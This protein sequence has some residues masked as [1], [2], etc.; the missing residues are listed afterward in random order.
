MVAYLRTQNDLID[1]PAL[2]QARDDPHSVDFAAAGRSLR[3]LPRSLFI[4]RVAV[5]NLLEAQPL[6]RQLIGCA[7][8]FGSAGVRHPRALTPHW[9]TIIRRRRVQ[10]TRHKMCHHFVSK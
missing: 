8:H 2:S 9:P 1:L 6:K 4:V 3:E 5:D 7:E 10:K